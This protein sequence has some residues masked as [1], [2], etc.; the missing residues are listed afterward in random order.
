MTIGAGS[1]V[2]TSAALP[3]LRSG[4]LTEQATQAL[5]QLILDRGFP[6]N[7]LPNEPTLAT[8]MG[9]SRT[10]VRAALQS[11]E[12]LGVISRAPGKGT[13]VRPQVDRNCM[14]LHRL[15]GFR[16]M[17]EAK[18][19]NVRVEQEFRVTRQGSAGAKAALGAA[20]EASVLV[21][22][23]IISADGSQAVHLIQEVPVAFVEPGLADDLVSGS[24]E[25]PISLFE[26]SRFWPGREIETTV[27]DIVPLIVPT[28][29]RKRPLGLRAGT[30]YLELREVHYSDKNEAVAY[31]VEEIRDDLVRMRLV[32]NR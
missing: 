16:G 2:G 6:N 8:E 31:S 25:P 19:D 3:R 26:F 21:N 27:L 13:M 17:L 4:S 18:Y 29:R 24:A 7:R 10:T 11:L 5:L 1:S 23:K 22:D 32:R 12:R 14:L 30:P 20:A 28:S 9:I 15:I